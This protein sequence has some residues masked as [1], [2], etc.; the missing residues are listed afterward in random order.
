MP[1]TRLRIELLDTQ[2]LVWRRMLVPQQISLH[3]LLKVHIAAPAS[4]VPGHARC[5]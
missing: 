1:D 5:G 4:S 3:R 2:P